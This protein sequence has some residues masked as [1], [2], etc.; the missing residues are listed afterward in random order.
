[1]LTL[2]YTQLLFDY[3][4]KTE[5]KGHKSEIKDIFKANTI[6]AIIYLNI[7][8]LVNYIIKYDFIYFV[9]G[10]YSYILFLA[11]KIII[12]K[13]YSYLRKK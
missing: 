4:D 2:F 6:V 13:I 1:M 9:I 7:S 8:I 3:L 12:A 5:N 10:A 11:L